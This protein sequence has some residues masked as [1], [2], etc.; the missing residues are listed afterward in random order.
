MYSTSTLQTHISHLQYQ[1]HILCT[2]RVPTH[3]S[4]PSQHRTTYLHP[5]LLIKPPSASRIL[6]QPTGV[7]VS[8][9][10]IIPQPHLRRQLVLRLLL[11]P[12]KVR[13]ELLGHLDHF[14]N[15]LDSH[16]DGLGRAVVG[17]RFSSEA[18][19]FGEGDGGLETTSNLSAVPFQ[20]QQVSVVFDVV[21]D[22]L[23]DSD[24]AFALALQFREEGRPDLD[25]LLV[26]QW[27]EPDW[28][29]DAA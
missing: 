13:F 7:R 16:R 21:S 29:V 5:P 9:R 22:V 18:F 25:A 27:W 14:G 12:V 2:N 10:R 11:Q 19:D 23:R 3:S 24:L 1:R 28:S 8:K 4:L 15:V 20:R 26:G 6:I 17:A